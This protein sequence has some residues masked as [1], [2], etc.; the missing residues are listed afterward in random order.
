MDHHGGFDGGLG[1]RAAS[2]GRHCSLEQRAEW[3]L[4][5]VVWLTFSLVDA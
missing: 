4:A 3:R 5:A 2:S 1:C